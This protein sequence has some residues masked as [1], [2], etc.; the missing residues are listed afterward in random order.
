VAR[1]RSGREKR[2]INSNVTE[3]EGHVD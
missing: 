3:A 1:T 2:P